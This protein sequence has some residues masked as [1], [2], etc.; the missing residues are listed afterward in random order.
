V[1]LS[2]RINKRFSV[3]SG[4]Y[5]S[6]IGQ[7]LSGISSYSGFGKY[8]D[9]KSSGFS[10][11][12]ASGTIYTDNDD[13]FLLDNNSQTKYSNDFDPVKAELQYIDNSL[14][15]SFNYLELPVVVRYKVVDKTLDFNIIGGVS[16]NVLVSNTVSAGSTGNKH[17]IG[18]TDGLNMLTFSSSLGMGMEYNLSEKLS[19]NLEPVFRY[20]I[21]PFGAIPGMNIHPYSFGVFSGISY[22]F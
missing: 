18:G 3:Q 22:R 20:Y 15:Q 9:S 13:V 4:I 16:S 12:S 1:A 21:N 10:V 17:K 8:N 7:E 2:Y 6:N 14:R 19:M 5:Y 11:I